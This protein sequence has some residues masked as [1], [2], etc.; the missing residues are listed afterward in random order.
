VLHPNTN[1]RASVQIGRVLSCKCV[2]VLAPEPGLTRFQ[3]SERDLLGSL[4][5]VSMSKQLDNLNIKHFG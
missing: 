5:G 3:S 4:G 2:V 1:P